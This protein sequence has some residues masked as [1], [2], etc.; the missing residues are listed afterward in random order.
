[1]HWNGHHWAPARSPAIGGSGLAG[2]LALTPR[3]AWAAGSYSPRP[4]VNRTLIER[5]D[6][7]AWTVTP[8]PN[9]RQGSEL[10]GIAGTQQHL[11]AVGDALTD[12]LI[13]RR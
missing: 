3:L 1:M 7:R 13:L 4:G 8:S 11:W 10:L 6:G 5:W 2:V 9:R 12:T